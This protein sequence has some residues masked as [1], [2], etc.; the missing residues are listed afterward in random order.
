MKIAFSKYH[1][2]GNDFIIIDDRNNK[3]QS[4]LS[5]KIINQLCKRRFGIGA[6]GLILL[7]KHRSLDFKMIY[8]N[9]D[10][11]ESSMC[12]NGGR[13]LIHFAKQLKVFKS[14]CTFDAIDGLHEGRVEKDKVHLKMADVDQIKK[15]RQVYVLDT[16]SPHYVKF[17]EDVA[18]LNVFKEGSKIRYNNTYS[19]NGINVNFVQ[20]TSNRIQVRTYERGVEDET[21]SC[22]TGVVASSIATILEHKLKNKKVAIKT[23]GGNLEVTFQKTHKGFENIWLIGPAVLVNSGI[24]DI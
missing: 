17:V 24:V 23:L 4:K 15:Y 13:C 11:K 16:G 7:K 18:N 3:I 19:K 22:G 1:G 2:T 21:Y 12:G 10:G 6:D 14:H 9:A 5:P 8:Y 20:C